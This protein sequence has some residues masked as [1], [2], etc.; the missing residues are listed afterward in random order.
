MN[1]RTWIIALCCL[2]FVGIAVRLAGLGS[3]FSHIDDLNVAVAINNAQ[4]GPREAGYL[5]KVYAVA[6]RTTYAPLQYLLTALLISSDQPYRDVLWW[7][8]FPSFL[9]GALGLALLAVWYWRFRGSEGFPSMLLAVAVAAFSW[10]NIIYAKQM[11]SY[12]IGIPAAVAVLLLLQGMLKPGAWTYP[13][14][15]LLGL[16]L[17]VLCTAQYQILFFLPGVFI[18]LFVSRGGSR[19][20]MRDA[21]ANLA[22][23]LAVV[24]LFIAPLYYFFIRT[25]PQKA[26]YISW[27]GGVNGEY[28][29]SLPSGILEAAWYSVR[30][31]GENGIAVFRNT[32]ALL[33]AGH[34]LA[35]PLE[36]LLLAL[37][38][39]GA[40][41]CI[42]TKDRHRRML[43]L[44][45]GVT[46]L[47][48]AVLIVMRRL[49]F[50]PTRHTLILL[51]LFAI[52]I[53]EGLSYLIGKVRR[54]GIAA[55][56]RA[57]SAPG[58]A[59]VMALLFLAS[60][61]GVFASRRDPFD[62]REIV[63]VLAAHKKA[64][65]IEYDWTMNL[66][67]MPSVMR[68]YNVVTNFNYYAPSLQRELIGRIPH[69]GAIVFVSHRGPLP[70]QI[71]S[72]LA[73]DGFESTGLRE[74]PSET[75]LDFSNKTKNGSNGFYLTVY[76]HRDR[77]KP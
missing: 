7:G 35:A 73:E 16:G 56:L 76:E 24:L 71:A 62:E 54:E 27:N 41:S 29:F 70:Q 51:P 11:S 34:P 2:L 20:A 23:T 65:A 68:N 1:K 31:F 9:A 47:T 10:E 21:A 25:V 30:F 5:D 57:W 40:A 22:V 75:E 26:A 12:A 28:A 59:A 48:W 36:Y 33:P 55:R 72:I 52:G 45:A 3:H 39:A 32:V 61:P 53:G 15:L 17:G 77:K 44:F 66:L 37:F 18:A 14:M 6:N 63:S 69:D 13:R 42:D 4:D 8:R 50:G 58:L 64:L 74:A 49:S 38:I 19:E 43:G 46:A 60:A 67:L